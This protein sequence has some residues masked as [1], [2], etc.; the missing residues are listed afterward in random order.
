MDK[1]NIV[2]ILL[3]ASLFTSIYLIIDNSDD[4]KSLYQRIKRRIY[5]EQLKEV[6]NEINRPAAVQKA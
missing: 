3:L 6:Q 2:I 4:P 5:P 1:K